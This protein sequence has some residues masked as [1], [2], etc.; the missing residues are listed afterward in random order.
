MR[1][2]ANT[3]GQ[4]S[5]CPNGGDEINAARQFDQADREGRLG[6]GFTRLFTGGLVWSVAWNT[7]LG[8]WHRQAGMGPLIPRTDDIM[9]HLNVI[10]V[11]PNRRGDPCW[12]YDRATD[13]LNLDPNFEGEVS[14]GN[15]DRL[16]SVLRCPSEQLHGTLVKSYK[17]TKTP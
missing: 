9:L 15:S 12:R 1:N 10:A 16:N 7:D 13:R 6:E 2:V 3:G 8:Y 11:H 14:K 5:K 17:V 4:I